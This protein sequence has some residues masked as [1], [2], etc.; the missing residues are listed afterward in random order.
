MN[1]RAFRLAP[2]VLA[3]AVLTV[4]TWAGT[5]VVGIWQ[6]TLAVNAA[7]QL[8]IVFHVSEQPDKTLTATMD[9]PDQGAT[10]IKV[11]TAQF[12]DSRIRFYSAAVQGSYDGALS[13][14]SII[15]TWRQGGMGFPLILKKIEKVE[16]PNRP[17]EPK[18]PYP[19]LE[20]EV[21][22]PNKSARITLAGTLTRPAGKG[23]FPAVLLITGSGPQNRD[24]EILGHR[25]F[26]VLADYLTRRG[27]AV[28][29]VDDRGVG[30]STGSAAQ[31]AS[32][33]FRDDVL[34]GVA[35]LKTRAEIDGRRIGLLGHSVGGLIAPMAAAESRDVAFIVLIAGPGVPGDSILYLQTELIL[36]GMGATDSA[37]ARNRRLQN[38]MFSAVRTETD[39]ARLSLELGRLI[40]DAALIKDSAEIEATDTASAAIQIA[41]R[42][43]NSPWM[44][45]FISYDPRPSLERVRCPVLAINGE[46][47]TQVP[48]KQNLPV[49]EEALKAGGN[50]DYLVRELPG[51]NHLLQTA[52]TGLP[53]EYAS[54]E[55][56]MSPLALQ[57][58]GDWIVAHTAKK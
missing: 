19:Y 6:G 45:F 15:G 56:T 24:E 51:L 37:I 3:M 36:K 8:R 58:I 2:A 49:I 18:K 47:D 29:R 11:D 57:T 7:V 40:R 53:S 39:T 10:G 35:Y 33:D 12:A 55:E 23:P 34:S 32:M 54:I 9:S 1:G 14:D 30:K 25:P 20:E 46:K 5:D 41:V 28:L 48:P 31:A 26:L 38:S 17:Q 16:V 4:K 13:G 43:M 44:R 50:R 27:I 21:A 22:Y 42:Q 52:K